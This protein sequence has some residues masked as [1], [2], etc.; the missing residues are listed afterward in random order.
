M[1]DFKRLRLLIRE[2]ERLQ[3]AVEKAEARATRSSSSITGMPRGGRSGNKMEDDTI[4]IVELKEK[5]LEITTELEQQRKELERAL[6]KVTD[7]N[8][9]LA[10]RMRYIR[11]KKLREIEIAMNY[12]ERSII[13]FLESGE[14]KV[15]EI[16][17]QK[18]RPGKVGGSWQ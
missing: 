17:K 14:R 8:Q 15:I 12:S 7:P 10:L 13:R 11:G 6:K 5:H 9:Y 16:Q 2:D 3:W 4:I 1:I 18:R